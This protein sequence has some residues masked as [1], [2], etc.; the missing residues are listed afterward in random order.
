MPVFFCIHSFTACIP[1]LNFTV[2][3]ANDERL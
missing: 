3:L 1:S 2:Y